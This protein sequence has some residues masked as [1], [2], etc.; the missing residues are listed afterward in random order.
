MWHPILTVLEGTLPS[1]WGPML[2]YH[3]ATGEH[4]HSRR[5]RRD[6]PATAWRRF[7]ALPRQERLAAVGSIID[8]LRGTSQIGNPHAPDNNRLLLRRPVY[9]SSHRSE[10]R[11]FHCSKKV[12]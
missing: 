12:A 11:L 2:V 3:W 7:L 8:V 10:R 4:L 9:V 6:D 5:E 1:S